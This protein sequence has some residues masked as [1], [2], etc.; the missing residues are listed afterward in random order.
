MDLV[1][2]AMEEEE[3]DK[4]PHVLLEGFRQFCNLE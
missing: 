4:G 3:K 2:Y 1:C